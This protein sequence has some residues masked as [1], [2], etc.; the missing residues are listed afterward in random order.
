[1]VLEALSPPFVLRMG[2]IV[3]EYAYLVHLATVGGRP[4]YSAEGGSF[5][6][7]QEGRG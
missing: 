1:M 7:G 4:S 6:R 2:Q 5:G 3:S